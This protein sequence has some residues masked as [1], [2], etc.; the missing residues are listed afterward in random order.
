MGQRSADSGDEFN[1]FDAP[2]ETLDDEHELT[3]RRFR[4]QEGFPILNFR[5]WADLNPRHEE[6]FFFTT[7]YDR[8]S[9]GLTGEC[10]PDSR[11]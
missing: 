10:S 11:P 8:F 7:V 4:R 1:E 5:Q 9:A 3:L 2:W 6:I